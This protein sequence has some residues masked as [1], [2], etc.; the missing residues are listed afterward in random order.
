MLRRLVPLQESAEGVKAIRIRLAEVLAELGRREEALDAARR[1]LEVEPH[2]PEDLDRV[3]KLFTQ[4]AR[5]R[6]RGPRARA[7]GE[8]AARRQRSRPGGGDAVRGRRPLARPG[9]AAGERGPGAREDP[10]ARPGEPARLRAR[11]GPVHPAQRLAR[12]RHARRPLHPAPGHRRGEARRAPGPREG[13]GAEARPEGH[14]VHGGLPRPEPL[15]P[16]RRGPRGGR[17]A[18]R[19]DRL[20][21]RARR[22]LR[23]G[24]R[25]SPA[26]PARRAA[27]PHAREG[28][29]QEARRLDRRR[30]LAPEDPRVRPDERARARRPRGDVRPPRREQGVRRRAR[31]EARDRRLDR[32][33]QADPP[34]DRPGLRRD[35]AGPDRGRERAPARARPRA[36]RRDA[37]GAGRA[38]PPRRRSG[39]SSSPRCSGC[40]TSSAGSTRRPRSRSRSRRSTSATCRTT[41]ARSPRYRQALEFDPGCRE[42]LE[43][44]ERLYTKLDRP[45]ELLE[46]YERQLEPDRRLPREGEGALQE[47]QHLGGQVPQPPERGPLRRGRAPDRARQ[48]PGDRHPRAA[49]PRAGPLGGARRGARPP[50]PGLAL[51][52]SSRPSCSCRWA[53]STTSSSSRWT[54]PSTAS[55]ARTRPTRA[56]ARRSTRSGCSTSA[57]ATGPTRSR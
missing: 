1:A 37:A 56:R 21:R 45:A 47:R 25:R 13:A 18:R 38:P 29:G 54:A 52:A 12:V 49:P 4:L 9:V 40:E 31:A 3:Q 42:A 44:L 48:P 16:D 39:T 23:A 36:G 24:R 30:G 33:A 46:V 22:R 27:L 53:R 55:P 51:D 14:G 32:A 17:A 26:R 35:D 34:R 41:R 20:A 11:L 15:A 43:S 19:G 28:A 10:R 57:P 8:R 6:R 7:E 2:S 5:V 50:P